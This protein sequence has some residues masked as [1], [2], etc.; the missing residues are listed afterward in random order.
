[1]KKYNK[2]FYNRQSTGSASSA[3]II[4]PLLIKIFTPESV[5]D[6]GCGVGTWLKEFIR[7]GVLTCTGIDSHTLFASMPIGIKYHNI[8]LNTLET[9]INALTNNSAKWDMAISLETAEHLKSE[10]SRHFVKALT[11]LSCPFFLLASS[12]EGLSDWNGGHV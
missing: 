9:N 6:V 12:S 11:N 10:N 1:M 5:I 8:D 3:S 4:V 2:Q 7:Q